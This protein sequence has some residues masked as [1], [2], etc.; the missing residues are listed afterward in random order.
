M[1]AL[2]EQSEVLAL[3][4]HGRVVRRRHLPIHGVEYVA[5]IE[6]EKPARAIPPNAAHFK[7]SEKSVA[8]DKPRR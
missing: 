8:V 4:P 3:F 7:R 2:N 6:I 5:V 1:A